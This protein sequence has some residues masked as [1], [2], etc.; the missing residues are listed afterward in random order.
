MAGLL[1]L[2]RF[3]LLSQFSGSLD[4]TLATVLFQVFVRHDFATNKLVLEVRA[5]QRSGEGRSDSKLE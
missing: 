3:P 5:D 1:T 2:V 4:S